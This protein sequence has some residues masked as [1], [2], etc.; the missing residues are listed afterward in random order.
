MVERAH[1]FLGRAKA[2]LKCRQLSLG[3]QRTLHLTATATICEKN[4]RL[5]QHEWKEGW[6]RNTITAIVW[7]I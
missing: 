5:P 6:A 3:W 2:S 7:G 4:S 1:H